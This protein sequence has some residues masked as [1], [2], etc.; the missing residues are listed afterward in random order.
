M[1][2][3]YKGPFRVVNCSNNIYPVQNLVSSK[4]EVY[5]V[6][7][8]RPFLNDLNE[9]DPREVAYQLLGLVDVKAIIN[10]GLLKSI[11]RKV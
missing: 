9:T 7:N 5:H 10:K 11:I 3:Q 2:A 4:L 1:V 8:L 6:T